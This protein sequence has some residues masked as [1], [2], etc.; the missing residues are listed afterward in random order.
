MKTVINKNGLNLPPAGWEDY[1]NSLD[2]NFRNVYIFFPNNPAEIYHL[3]FV[4]DMARWRT[5]RIC[6]LGLI[7]LFNDKLWK[8]HKDLKGKEEERIM[9]RLESEVLLKMKYD[10]IK[11]ED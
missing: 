11:G 6:T 8:Y 3:A 2:S 7:G 10:Y 1:K 5:S 4:G 9:K